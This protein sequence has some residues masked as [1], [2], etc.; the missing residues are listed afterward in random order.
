MLAPVDS[1]KVKC[2]CT[3]AQRGYSTA[4]GFRENLS[5]DEE[6]VLKQDN[7]LIKECE[8]LTEEQ[9]RLSKDLE[10]KNNQH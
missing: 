10:T 2:P 1:A 7:M 5:R 9:T 6:R 3:L 8:D 4:Y